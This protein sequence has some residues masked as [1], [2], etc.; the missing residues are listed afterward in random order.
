MDAKRKGRD[1]GERATQNV[2][3]ERNLTATASRVE[4]ANARLALWGLL[5]VGLADWSIRKFG[6]A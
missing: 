3:A 1:G 5:R 4:T 6:G 2:S